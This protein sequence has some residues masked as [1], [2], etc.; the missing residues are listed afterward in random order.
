MINPFKVVYQSWD[1]SIIYYDFT[2][3]HIILGGIIESIDGSI[4]NSR[5]FIFDGKPIDILHNMFFLFMWFE[6]CILIIYHH[7]SRTHVL[8]FM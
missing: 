3:V 2:W 4:I 1:T 5:S 6:R 8:S 7:Y